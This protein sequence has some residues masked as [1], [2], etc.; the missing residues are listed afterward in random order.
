M[1]KSLTF[2]VRYDNELAHQYY[3]DGEKLTK[4]MQDI[5]NGKNLTFPKEYD[6]TSTYPP[7]SFMNVTA[8]DD[9]DVGD[10]RGVHVPSGLSVEIID[11]DE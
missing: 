6:T 2:D 7:I 4:R 3:G 8:E 5:Y 9:V 1:T 10:L 11:F